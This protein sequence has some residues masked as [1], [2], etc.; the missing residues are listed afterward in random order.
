MNEPT[1]SPVAGE[2]YP[3]TWS[4][5]EEWFA[6]ED[7]C[8]R[9]IERL[10]WRNGFECPRCGYR[11]EPYRGS[12]SRLICRSCHLQCAATSRT[13]FDKTRTPLKVW[14]AA[15]WYITS[16]KSGVSALGL[17]RVLGL[18]SYQTAWTMLHRFRRAMA[19]PGREQLKGTVEVDQSY[20]AIRERR[21][22]PRTAGQK[23]RTTKALIVIAVEILEPRGFGRIRL[24][25]INEETALDVYPFIDEV[26]EPGAVIR[27]D[28]GL[29]YSTVGEVYRH[30]RFP[31]RSV[32]P[33]SVPAHV[34]L[35]GVHRVASLL[36]RW[37]LGTHQGA[38]KPIQLDYYLDE[39]V[40]RF[41]RRTSRSRGLLFYR[42]IEQAV[43]TEPVTYKAVT[44]KPAPRKRPYSRNAKL[45]C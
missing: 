8:L 18:G 26:I 17:Q 39:F 24:R 40:F 19:R 45:W 10:R 25:R 16:Q 13:L 34:P 43:I 22:T 14:L 20:L 30:E 12:R 44:R 1:Y 7:D 32:M 31:V 41:N 28:G 38:V 29:I 36:K 21:E 42:L 35:P 5:F 11:D 37:L 4:Q 27:T 3:Q 2:D 6:T 33:D 9:Y 15:A 23:R